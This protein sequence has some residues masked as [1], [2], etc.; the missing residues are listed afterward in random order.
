MVSLITC[1]CHG[2]AN[3]WCFYGYGM[4]CYG[5]GMALV[6][7]TAVFNCSTY[8]RCYVFMV[9]VCVM[10]LW[11]GI[12]NVWWFYGYGMRYVVMVLGINVILWL[13]HITSMPHPCQGVAAGQGV[14]YCSLGVQTIILPYLCPIF[15]SSGEPV[16]APVI[17][18]WV[19][20]ITPSI[21]PGSVIRITEVV[22]ALSYQGSY[23][24]FNSDHGFF[25]KKNIV[26]FP[27]SYPQYRP[28]S[29]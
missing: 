23:R 11:Y 22:L 10:L 6:M 21:T 1:L 26:Y 2:V 7:V 16:L 27:L 9:M 25:W 14:A 8:A 18:L 15:F 5:Y 29:L 24:G 19:L 20:S 17:S 13:L 4:R 28:S 3:V 12:A